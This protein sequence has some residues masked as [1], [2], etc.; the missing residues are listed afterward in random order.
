MYIVEDI[1]NFNINHLY[2]S[3][4][5]DNTVIDGGNFSKIMY[6]TT[7][8]TLNGVFILCSFI[9]TSVEKN[10]YNKFKVSW[11]KDKNKELVEKLKQIEASILNRYGTTSYS[12]SLS[13]LLDYNNFRI[14][15]EETKLISN[16][17]FMLRISGLWENEK[18]SGITYKFLEIN[19]L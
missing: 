14:F 3:D 13:N 4:R 8:I 12:S 15:S 7:D 16:T 5:Q 6:S 9:N 18:G 11:N 1:D 19:N 17:D 2:V 10:A